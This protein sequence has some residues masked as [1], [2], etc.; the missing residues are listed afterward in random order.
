MQRTQE[1]YLLAFRR[2]M[3]FRSIDGKTTFISSAEIV[4]GVELIQKIPATR[5]APAL[6]ELALT[7]DGEPK[8]LIVEKDLVELHK[9][10]NTCQ[11]SPSLKSASCKHE[12]GKTP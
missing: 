2:S 4:P 12:E 8:V 1:T 10:R 11:L 7:L 5:E 3:T 6:Y 9:D